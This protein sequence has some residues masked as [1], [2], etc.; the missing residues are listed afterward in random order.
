MDSMA[1][2]FSRQQGE[3]GPGLDAMG[4]ARLRSQ[5]E[6]SPG[7]CG[8][9]TW[10]GLLDIKGFLDGSLTLSIG[11][12]VAINENFLQQLGSDIV[13]SDLAPEPR[14]ASEGLGVEALDALAA[15]TRYPEREAL[16]F[17]WPPYKASFA[18]DAILKHKE[19]TGSLPLKVVYVGEGMGGCTADDAFHEL[20]ATTYELVSV[21]PCASSDGI[22]D[23]VY[24]YK[25]GAE[26]N[27]SVETCFLCQCFIVPAIR[28]AMSS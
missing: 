27:S 21:I 11:A 4:L 6:S 9:V 14:V 5:V 24:L 19:L 8:K 20:L 2:S 1:W 7:S 28:V 25:L 13:A 17:C 16:F 22:D 18:V 10:Q 12:G 23:S 15:V 26:P 3:N